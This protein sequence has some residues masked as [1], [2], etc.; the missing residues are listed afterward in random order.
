MRRHDIGCVVADTA[1]RFPKAEVVTSDVVYVR[2]HGDTEL[3]TSGYSPEALEAWAER[4][5]E[6]ARE[7]DVYVYFDNDAKGFA[8]HDAVALSALL[9]L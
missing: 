5:R 7:Q 9:G 4:C 8:P 3:Y 6:W 2:L 1:G